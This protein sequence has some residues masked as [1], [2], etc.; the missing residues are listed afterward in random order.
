MKWSRSVVSDSANPGLP[1]C[2][3]TLYRLSHQRSPQQSEHCGKFCDERGLSTASPEPK[4][5]FGAGRCLRTG[6]QGDP[7]EGYV[8]TPSTQWTQ[9]NL[10]ADHF[11]SGSVG[12]AETAEG[13]GTMAAWHWGECF[14]SIGCNV[15]P[16][17]PSWCRREWETAPG[18][19]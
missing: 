2:R 1:H 17:S 5:P 9:W 14:C 18:S 12:Q 19:L 3:Q 4:F 16:Q 7:N 13:V 15:K 10:I 6:T 8:V 11:S